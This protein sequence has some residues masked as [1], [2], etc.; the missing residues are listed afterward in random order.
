MR[1]EETYLENLRAFPCSFD[2][3]PLIPKSAKL[4]PKKHK[5][6]YLQG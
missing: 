1:S 4:E 5:I 6:F 2:L 3:F